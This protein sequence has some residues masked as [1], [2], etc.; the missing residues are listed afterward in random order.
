M[1]SKSHNREL[2]LS[3]FSREREWCYGIKSMCRGAQHR[4]TPWWRAGI[5]QT[6]GESKLTDIIRI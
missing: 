2:V 1:S 4:A 6:G 5:L 3:R